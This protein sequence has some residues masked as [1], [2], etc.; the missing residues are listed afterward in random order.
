MRARLRTAA[1][2]AK[3]DFMNAKFSGRALS[4]A[5]LRTSSATRLAGGS[6]LALGLALLLLRLAR[7]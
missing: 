4:L 6:A 5:I 1:F 3:V 2:C 7:T